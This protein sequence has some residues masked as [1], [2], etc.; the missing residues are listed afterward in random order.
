MRKY[1]AEVL[2][3]LFGLDLGIA[4]GAGIYEARVVVP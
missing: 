3:W 1:V 4:F 2:L